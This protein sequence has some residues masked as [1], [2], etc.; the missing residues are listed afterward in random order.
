M[1]LYEMR[2]K[3]VVWRKS[4]FC[5]AGE[6]AEVAKEQDMI[7]LRSTLAPGVVVRYTLEEFR[8]LRLGFQAGEFDDLA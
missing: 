3:T 6:C 4:S 2:S 7:L 1:R 8:A 5:A